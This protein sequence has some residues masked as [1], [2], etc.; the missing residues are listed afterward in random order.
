MHS[1]HSATVPSIADFDFERYKRQENATDSA[2]SAIQV[3][4][5]RRQDAKSAWHLGDLAPTDLSNA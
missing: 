2:K 5:A 1:C 3:R 4:Y